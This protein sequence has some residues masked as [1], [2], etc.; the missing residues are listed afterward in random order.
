[1]SASSFE[2]NYARQRAGVRGFVRPP[3][4]AFLRDILA[5]LK[6]SVVSVAR[7]Q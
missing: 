3:S 6:V 2:L 5:A 1:V 4:L 7:D